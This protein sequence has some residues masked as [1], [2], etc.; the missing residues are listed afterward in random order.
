MFESEWI[1]VVSFSYSLVGWTIKYGKRT[2]TDLANELSGEQMHQ[3]R[4]IGMQ[5]CPI[6]SCRG[7]YDFGSI[8]FRC[9]WLVT[10]GGIGNWLWW[11]WHILSLWLFCAGNV[12]IW[13]ISAIDK[14]VEL[15]DCSAWIEGKEIS[16]VQLPSGNKI[17]Q[18]RSSVVHGLLPLLYKQHCRLFR[19]RFRLSIRL[20]LRAP[21]LF[22]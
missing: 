11:V 22:C 8:I 4:Q 21:K 9:C 5:K 16:C 18:M 17:C 19:V 12:A 3:T 13:V 10:G 15:Q 6:I 14:L 7:D 20:S 2:A 1:N